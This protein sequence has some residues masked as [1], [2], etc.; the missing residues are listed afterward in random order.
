MSINFATKNV[1][2]PGA[3]KA[4]IEKH[5]LDIEKIA[6]EIIDA[7]VIV[8]EEKLSFKVEI[9]LKTRLNSFY[10]E[11][12][13]K[14]L[15]QAVRNTLATVRNQAKKSKEK[16]KEEKKR[17]KARGG[18][19]KRTLG[20]MTGEKIEPAETAQADSILI[21]DNYSHKPITVEEAVF[22]LNESRENGYMFINAE[23]SRM[24]AVFRNAQGNI[25]LIE[26]N[27]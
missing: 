7:D 13:N 9:S 22:F 21:S 14:I 4:F 18:F 25:S 26:P 19:F 20:L 11:E 23:T 12:H 15:K 5:L 3:L 17:S 24:A 10:A 16:I 27:L 6:G 2:M 8:N 1:K